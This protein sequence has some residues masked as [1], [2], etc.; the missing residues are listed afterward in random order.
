MFSLNLTMR[1]FYVLMK[2]VISNRLQE[3]GTRVR[4][5]LELT[6]KSVE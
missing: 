2:T 1:R 6:L 4:S 3:S 5:E